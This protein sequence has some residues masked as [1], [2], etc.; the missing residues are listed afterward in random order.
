MLFFFRNYSETFV[1]SIS[2]IF[3][4]K[5]FCF[6]YYME[7]TR[8]FVFINRKSISNTS[9]CLFTREIYPKDYCV[10]KCMVRVK[11]VLGVLYIL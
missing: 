6:E 8:Y 7:S 4:I 10:K 3:C 2:R 5:N 1:L 9:K 11:R